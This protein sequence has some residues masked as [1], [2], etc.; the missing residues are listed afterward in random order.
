M[1]T[2]RKLSYYIP[3]SVDIHNH[4]NI[5]M[6]YLFHLLRL[7]IITLLSFEVRTWHS[8][9]LIYVIYRNKAT[10][11]IHSVA[12]MLLVKFK[13]IELLAYRL[14]QNAPSRVKHDDF[15]FTQRDI[16][17]TDNVTHILKKKHASNLHFENPIYCKY[18]VTNSRYDGLLIQPILGLLNHG[19]FSWMDHLL[20][21]TVDKWRHD[22]KCSLKPYFL[23][24]IFLWFHPRTW[25]IW[26][27]DLDAKV[28]CV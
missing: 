23:I 25:Y 21:R 4:V 16:P 28:L 26:N 17:V 12:L 9:A 1:C 11:R 5:Y 27:I 6:V 20:Y 10:H 14:L 3:F 18:I 7:H 8:C 13:S 22:G 19:Y 15:M 2:S 24:I